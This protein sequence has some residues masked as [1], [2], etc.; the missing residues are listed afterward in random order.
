MGGEL[1]LARIVKLV[2]DLIDTFIKNSDISE[3]RIEIAELLSEFRRR[4]SIEIAKEEAFVFKQLVN[5]VP[6]TIIC[7]ELKKKHPDLIFS[8]NDIKT[9]LEHNN[10]LVDK[11]KCELGNTARRHLSAKAKIEEELA[12]LYLFTKELLKK[13]DQEGDNNSTLGAIKALNQTLVNYCRL[14]GIG[15]F[16]NKGDTNIAVNVGNE[17]RNAGTLEANFKMVQE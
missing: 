10:E 6:K 9:F 13:Y 12:S 14:T 15:N 11:M 4:S 7:E 3:K 17:K 8:I 1:E 16:S 5:G 2:N